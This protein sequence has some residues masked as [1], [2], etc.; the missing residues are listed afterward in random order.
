MTKQV[1]ELIELA[2]DKVSMRKFNSNAYYWYV[3][4]LTTLIDLDLISIDR[5][6]DLINEMQYKCGIE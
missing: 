3:G 1:E 4:Y 2:A 6:D 5:F